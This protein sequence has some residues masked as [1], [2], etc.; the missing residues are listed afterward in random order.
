MTCCQPF[1]LEKNK[2]IEVARMLRVW[3][4]RHALK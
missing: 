2:S 4:E 3:V 1:N